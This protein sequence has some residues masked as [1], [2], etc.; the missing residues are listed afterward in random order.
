[1]S[2]RKATQPPPEAAKP[3]A[4]K[5]DHGDGGITLRADGRWQVRVTVTDPL[6]GETRRPSRYAKTEA[7]AK[8]LRRRLAADAQA[9]AR[10]AVAPRTVASILDD[11][12]VIKTPQLRPNSAAHYRRVVA[13]HILPVLGHHRAD[14][15]SAR[16]VQDW[17]A[18]MAALAPVT[19]RMRL[20]VLRG[21]LAWAQ[22]AGLVER[23][24]ATLVKGPTVRRVERPALTPDQARAL[25]ATAEGGWEEVLLAL[26]LGMSFRRGEALG[27]RWSAVDLAAGSVEVR[28]QSLHIEGTRGETPD[29]PTKTPASRRRVP[30]PPRVRRALL[31]QRDRQRMACQADS[32]AWSDAHFVCDPIGAG[33]HSRGSISRI[34]RR[35]CQA[36]GLP[37]LR[38]H[39][40]R[41][42]CA[43]LLLADGVDVRTV[44]QVLGHSNSSMTLELYARVNPQQLER[45][46]ESMGRT[47]GG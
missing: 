20:T 19:V 9:G 1:M 15:L 24:V 26:A 40:L 29:Q 8:A 44:M 37:H 30:L 7:E 46:G 5:S 35:A 45:A 33:P 41:G 14:R 3:R 34:M 38:F 39:D 13:S 25:L 2:P 42:V 32:V 11:W 10:A 22:A 17:L 47:L 18:G 23:N 31:A 28:H 6:T 4:R 16:H 27:L 12:L 43:S 21:G 36:A